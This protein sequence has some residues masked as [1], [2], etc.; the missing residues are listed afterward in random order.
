MKCPDL[1]ER[2]LR[3]SAAELR[4]LADLYQ[5]RFA[6]EAILDGLQVLASARG[7]ELS[8]LGFVRSG[9]T[10]Q[11]ETVHWLSQTGCRAARELLPEEAGS[12][13]RAYAA[14]RLRHELARGALYLA[15]RRAGMPPGAYRAEPR[16]AYRSAA[17]L[18]QRTLVPDCSVTAGPRRALCE[19]DCGTEGAQQLR[20]KWLRYRE[21]LEEAGE[22]RLYVL[23]V[24]TA[25]LAATLAAAGLQASVHDSPETLARAMW[26]DLG[27]TGDEA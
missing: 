8:R 12:G 10:A 23:C 17:G 14:L 2:L 1:T 15:L 5:V 21:W 25:S 6:D 4:L 24:E 13:M 18:G 16:L 19:V 3:L 9:A 22:R 27:G 11:G 20:H 26:A 7:E